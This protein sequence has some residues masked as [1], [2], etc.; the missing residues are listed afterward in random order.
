[1]T[2][3]DTDINFPALPSGGA[4]KSCPE[5]G[6]ILS[7]NTPPELCPHCLLGAGMRG[8]SAPV[9]YQDFSISKRFGPYQLGKLLGKGGMGEVYEADDLETGRRIALKIL[10]QRLDSPDARRRFL[11]EGRIAANINHPNS[12][13]VFG[14]EEVA[15]VPV[16]AMELMP[17]GTL[18]DKVCSHGPL[19]F[20]EAADI[21]LQ[22][23]D[24]LAAAHAAGILHRDIKTSNCFV[25]A[26]GSIKI[27]D[28]GLSISIKGHERPPF[29]EE[30]FMGTPMFAPPEQIRGDDLTVRSDIYSLGVNLYTLLAGK[31][32]FISK[33]TVRLLVKV[34]EIPAPELRD[35]RSDI[36]KG[37][38]DVVRRCLEK[39]PDDRF[40]GCAEL[41]AALIPFSSR[42]KTAAQPWQRLFAGIVDMAIV[43][44]PFLIASQYLS[45][46]FQA[47]KELFVQCA[48]LIGSVISWL[49]WFT[50]FEWKCGKTPGKSLFG[51][52][53][54]L[55]KPEDNQWIKG[56][57]ILGR[58]FLFVII[59]VAVAIYFFSP[60]QIEDVETTPISLKINGREFTGSKTRTD[61]EW[62]LGLLTLATWAAA[63]LLL[64]AGSS[65]NTGWL[66]IHDKLTD[67][68]VVSLVRQRR[69]RS[70]PN[71]IK[72]HSA[73]GST[74]LGPFLILE[75]LPDSDEWFV[76]YDPKLLRK[77]WLR[78]SPIGTPPVAASLRNLRRP[79]RLRWL[80][81]IRSPE[82]NWD[83]YEFPGGKPLVSFTKQRVP[84][85]ELFQ[86]MADLA[87][88][89][90]VA[91]SDG[92]QP[93]N[94]C[95]EQIWIN[96]DGRAKLLDFPAPGSKPPPSLTRRSLW[97][98]LTEIL[99]KKGPLPLPVRAFLKKMPDIS[100]PATITHELN[101]LTEL[102]HEVSRKKRLGIIAASATGPLLLG[103]GLFFLYNTMLS[104]TLFWSIAALIAFVAIPAMIFAAFAGDGLILRT[105]GLCVVDRNGNP[106]AGSLAA[107]RSLIAWLPTLTSPAIFTAWMT[108]TNSHY[109]ATGTLTTLALLAFISAILPERALHDRLANTFL[110]PR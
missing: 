43:G 16:I 109:A 26:D 71:E 48:L 8:I 13:Y 100:D 52:E 21:T 89:L 82:V 80:A 36:P 41:R 108:W 59:P 94:P 84:W 61:Y 7:P 47:H 9:P 55:S 5:C 6:F 1:M 20:T 81:G 85:Y 102:P 66:S 73:D 76:G 103:L 79:G 86:W 15:G 75:A 10:S 40:A 101:Q 58:S 46:N 97:H 57:R 35:I 12:V 18:L 23:I 32:P 88:E 67:T 27:G 69:P 96:A 50:L 24:G 39:R 30:S 62:D 60:I 19:S 25:D 91:N 38:A 74:M 34:L 106:A 28:Y 68:H 87:T 44:I 92:T 56:L 105:F 99:L 107:R 53:V 33:D 51:L 42:G 4:G 54:Q 70:K 63:T 98:D 31:P 93:S 64:F 65:R 2:S 22:I 3:P 83:A 90:T 77:I 45:N 78:K 49:A 14:A 95:I 110:V 11:N 17:G 72:N 29:D 37:L 104:T